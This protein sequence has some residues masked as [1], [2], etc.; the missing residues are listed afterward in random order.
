VDGD[1]VSADRWG[2]DPPTFDH[3]IVDLPRGLAELRDGIAPPARNQGQA[4][5]RRLEQMQRDIAACADFVAD[6][7]RYRDA[8]NTYPDPCLTPLIPKL[9]GRHLEK[10]R[11]YAVFEGKRLRDELAVLRGTT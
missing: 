6:C 1:D 11:A 7:D 10:L 4:R 5:A 3:L 9:M 2:D 8:M